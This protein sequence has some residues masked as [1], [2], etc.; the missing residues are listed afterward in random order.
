MSSDLYA[1]ITSS[2]AEVDAEAVIEQVQ[3]ALDRG[4]EPLKI[5]QDGLVPGME[6]VGERFAS[7]E[8]FLPQLVIAGRT[9]QEAL[10]LLEPSLRAHNQEI[11]PVGTVVLG[12]V[13]G[14]IHEIGKSL[15]GTM[16]AANGF[17]VHD[18]GVDVP[19]TTFVDKVTET[20]AD[21]LALSAL[22]TTTM[23]AQRQVIEALSEAGIRDRVKVIVGGAPISQ[24]WAESIG[25]DGYAEDAVGALRVARQLMA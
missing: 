12:T 18:M 11:K 23:A 2:L 21:I 6:V 19:V 8:Y 20:R 13:K 24:E 16:L 9:M 7:G 1:E 14:D 5:I 10:K 15:V 25:A 22:L 4:V 17:K 3:R